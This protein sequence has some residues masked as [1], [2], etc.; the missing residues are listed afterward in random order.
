MNSARQAVA[1][2]RL[3]AFRAAVRALLPGLAAPAPS[4][5]PR[6]RQPSYGE[7]CIAMIRLGP[8]SRMKG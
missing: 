5:P 1:V 8:E 2:F 7:F 3:A 4:V 6:R